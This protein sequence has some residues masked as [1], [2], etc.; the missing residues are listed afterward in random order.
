[1]DAALT[2]LKADVDPAAQQ[3]DAGAVQDAYVGGTPEIPLYYRAEVDGYRCARRRLADVQPELRRPHL[4]S[5]G[6]VLQAVDSR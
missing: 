6:L 2:A 3:K 4:G 5:R 1:M